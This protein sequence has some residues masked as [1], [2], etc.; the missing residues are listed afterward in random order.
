MPFKVLNLTNV[1]MIEIVYHSFS[2][3]DI[4]GVNVDPAVRES[5]W[6][7][8]EVRRVLLLQ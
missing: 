5:E 3:E 2:A 6:G 8:L 1:T 4:G 7:L